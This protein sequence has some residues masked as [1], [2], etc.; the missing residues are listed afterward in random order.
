M[1]WSF[2]LLKHLCRYVEYSND[3]GESLIYYDQHVQR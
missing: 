1:R 3:Y 2:P